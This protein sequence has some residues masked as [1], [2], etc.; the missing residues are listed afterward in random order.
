MSRVVFLIAATSLFGSPGVMS[1]QD[2]STELVRAELQ[3]QFGVLR[4]CYLTTSTTFRVNGTSKVGFDN[5]AFWEGKIYRK[6][7]VW[8]GKSWFESRQVFDGERT[9]VEDIVTTPPAQP[10][11]SPASITLSTDTGRIRAGHYYMDSIGG[12][13]SDFLVENGMSLERPFSIVAALKRNPYV[14]GDK[15]EV[16]NNY[17][18]LSM[19]YGEDRISICREF[20]FAIVR[21]RVGY[22]SKKG[23]DF[24]HEYNNYDFRKVAQNLWL[25]NRTHVRVT[26]SGVE[27]ENVLSRLVSI[28]LGQDVP[29][30]LFEISF[31]PGTEVIDASALGVKANGSAPAVSYRIEKKH[32]DTKA[33]LEQAIALR[34]QSA[35]GFGRRGVLVVG[36]ALLVAV[37]CLYAVAARWKR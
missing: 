26:K 11:V 3:S 23:D 18:C 24:I 37:A 15:E 22:R 34:N 31:T 8:T 30:G 27:S 33:N 1:G 9:G 4:N 16:V 7:K 6:N 10:N 17:K 13:F 12:P 14:I 21:R 19:T 35:G 29:S 5:I 36:F 32:E 20:G 28:K 2:V 25:P